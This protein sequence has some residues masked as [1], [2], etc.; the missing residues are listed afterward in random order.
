MRHFEHDG[1]FVTLDYNHSGCIATARSD[2]DYFKI[3]YQ[4]Y[5]DRQIKGRVKTQIDH[6]V[7]HNIKQ[8]N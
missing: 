1:Y 6:R 7:E 5:S 8:G 2:D 3:N 4:G